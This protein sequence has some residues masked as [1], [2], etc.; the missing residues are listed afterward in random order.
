MIKLIKF[1]LGTII[2]LCFLI[3]VASFLVE[4]K[5][6]VDLIEQLI[7]QEFGA[8]ISFN[9]DVSLHF[10]PFPSVKINSLKY[11]NKNLDLYV[12]K[13]N[14][15]LTWSSIL[16]LKPEI[17]N[18][19]LYSP[20]LKWDS[21]LKLSEKF[22]V[23][24]N[25]NNENFSSKL[26]EIS[27]K[28][29]LIKIYDGKVEIKNQ[30]IERINSFNAVIRGKNNLR[31]NGDFF[32]VNFNSSL[33]FDLSQENPNEFNLIM[34][35]K[36]NEKNKIDFI[37]KVNVFDNDFSLIGDVQSDL[38]DLDELLVF[39]KSLSLFKSNKI[40][41][42]N[43]N[44]KT[45]KKINFFIKKLLLKDLTLNST[46]F[47]LLISN[48]AYNVIN[49]SSKFDESTITGK[50][51][52]FPENKKV[53]GNLYLK[54]FLVKENYFGRTKYDL[55]DGKFDCKIDFKYF[56]GKYKN[57]FKSLNS[58]GNCKSKNIK[59]KGINLEEIAKSVDSIGDFSTL[60]KT[61]NPKK[62]TGVS[63][64][65]KIDINFQTKNGVVSF[66]NTSASHSN[67]DLEVS[68]NYWLLDDK[69]NFRNKAYFKTKKFKKL[70]PL[71]ILIK[72]STK[73]Y[74][75]NYDYQNLKQKLFNEGVKKILNEKK[76]ITINPEEIKKLF[77]QKKIDPN[78]IIDLF[79]N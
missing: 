34:Q 38:L 13:L 7:K 22:L 67:L 31:A 69:I 55:F 5:K 23:K 39:N 36:I 3:F 44:I 40:I 63:T 11:T 30:K 43:S 26:N 41:S 42:I 46:K 73:D 15:S 29:D 9:D 72:G 14:I 45:N 37:G 66:K 75:I 27:K 2:T 19:E 50:G 24:V 35:Q 61:I 64:L 51:T 32:L 33:R 79:V 70:P 18:L 62:W 48:S 68:G 59:L 47:I 49:F 58:E 77:D 1:F 6:F 65:N 60:I 78:K 56:I 4:K 71:G 17:N 10:V 57:N 74:D 54:E 53:V 12:E 25:L 21:N 20:F 16:D 28:F 8:D 52:I 76:S